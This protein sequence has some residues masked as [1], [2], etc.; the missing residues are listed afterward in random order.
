[1]I[2]ARA[3]LTKPFV[4]VVKSSGNR[5]LLLSPRG[6]A[7]RPQ[8]A[9]VERMIFRRVAIETGFQIQGCVRALRA[10]ATRMA[11]RPDAW[12]DCETTDAR[13]L[14]TGHHPGFEPSARRRDLFLRLKEEQHHEQ[15]RRYF[16]R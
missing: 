13:Q 7:R 11:D 15:L 10:L 5:A 4:A 14:D 8:M 16:A 2:E 3:P 9:A 12:A 1:M 6:E